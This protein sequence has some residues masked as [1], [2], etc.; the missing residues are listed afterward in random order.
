MVFS[1]LTDRLAHA[2]I[3]SNPTSHT[4]D[5]EVINQRLAIKQTVNLLKQNSKIPSSSIFSSLRVADSLGQGKTDIDI[6]IVSGWRIDCLLV[7]NWSGEI[8][9]DTKN[10][11][12]VIQDETKKSLKQF[13]NP[14][15]EAH[16]RSMLVKTFLNQSSIAIKDYQIT[17]RLVLTNEKLIDVT[18]NMGIFNDS[19]VI[20]DIS[21]FAE[22]FI[23]SWFWTITDPILPS[24]FSGSISYKQLTS[25][26]L[27]LAKLGTFDVAF[28]SGGRKLIGDYQQNSILNFD[29]NNVEEI[30]M[31][32]KSLGI[33][34]RVK[35]LMG[36]FP[37][38]SCILWRRDGQGWLFRARQSTIL[39]PYNQ[40]INF[41]I[42]GE[43]QDAQIPINEI[44]KIIV[45]K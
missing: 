11:N 4:D 15:K 43:S 2:D 6:I 22:S 20:R 21:K 32:M 44:L 45:S 5:P 33:T 1:Q 3:A 7:H 10:D 25:I 28:L 40:T 9:W 14:I 24:I 13:E 23:N 18:I 27:A 38:V 16:R 26:H 42:N 30:E 8:N 39:M 17:G 41:R 29:R 36:F 37:E 35:S 31:K 12:F 34:G 19:S